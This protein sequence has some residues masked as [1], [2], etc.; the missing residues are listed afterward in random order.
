LTTVTRLT[1]GLR[2]PRN[3]SADAKGSIHDDET[4]T[5]LGFRAGTV[6]GDI[7]LEQF[8]G[9][10]V[11]AFGH[12]W[13]ERGWISMHFLQA[14]ADLEPVEAWLEGTG[15]IR[16]AGMSTPDGTGV[17]R[18]N[19]GI[20]DASGS[21]L[22]VRDKR[23]ADPSTMRMLRGVE[24]GTSLD[25]QRRGPNKDEQLARMRTGASTDPLSLYGDRS[26]W[27][28]GICSPLTTCQ[29]LAA[30]VT[31]SIAAAARDF[32]GMYGAIEIRHLDGP[33]FLDRTYDIEG[34][35]ICVSDSPKT[36]ILWFTTRATVIGH[37]SPVAEMTMMTRL[38]KESSPLYS[39]QP[40][41]E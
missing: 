30:G 31:D 34:E 23:P 8:G 5:T 36:E 1:T 13:F 9:L 28:G 4:A 2:A 32:V 33:V 25:R 41:H 27:G 38:L 12:E 10:C 40:R 3:L 18:G 39:G 22:T 14:T 19:V 7:H 15:Q 35:V 24:P 26:P 21:T 11:E 6:A 17:C 29:L 20:G 37:N 16:D